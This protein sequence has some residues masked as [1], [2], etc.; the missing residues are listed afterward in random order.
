MELIVTGIKER[1]D[2]I[3][4]VE[5][6]DSVSSHGSN[7]VKFWHGNTN[8]WVNMH[9]PEITKFIANAPTDI[10]DLLLEV[11]RLKGLLAA[12]NGY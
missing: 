1:L 12:Y 2:G 7:I 3:G 9:S 6:E 11:E 4:V 10:N 5:W 8:F